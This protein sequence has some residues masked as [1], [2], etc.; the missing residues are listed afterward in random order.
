MRCMILNNIGEI[1]K[2]I[3]NEHQTR[4]P[5]EIASAMDI[6]VIFERLGTIN[7]YYNK[8]LRTKQIHINVLLSDSVKQ[9]VCAHELGHAILHPDSNT[10]F[11]QNNT[12][13]SVDK[14][15]KE[16]NQFAVELLIPNETLLE[17]W[18]LTTAQLSRL[19]GY[20]RKMIEM[21]LESYRKL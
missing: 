7:G 12:F 16:A 18:Y 14:I 9:Y 2:L 4:N 1:I 10:P 17:N 11:L 5:F 6:L 8:I 20:D 21:R 15:E 3:C 19:L 13:L